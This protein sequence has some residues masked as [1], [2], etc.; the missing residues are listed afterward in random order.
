VGAVSTEV[1][2]GN[3][4][5]RGGNGRYAHAAG[6]GSYVTRIVGELRRKNGDCTSS[7][8]WFWQS[9]KTAG[10]MSWWPGG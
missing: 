9:T 2:R 5:I 8:A 6:T 10:S 3:Y 1:Y 4:R 7:L